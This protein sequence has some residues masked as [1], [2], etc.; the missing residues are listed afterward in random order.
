MK[1]IKDSICCKKKE[2][3]KQTGGGPVNNELS[4]VAVNTNYNSN[5]VMNICKCIINKKLK[6]IYNI[7]G[8]HIN[9]YSNAIEGRAN[10]NKGDI[11]NG[12]IVASIFV[13]LQKGGYI[14]KLSFLKDEGEKNDCAIFKMQ[15]DDKVKE[16]FNPDEICSIKEFENILNRKGVS[17]F[18]KIKDYFKEKGLYHNVSYKSEYECL[19]DNNKVNSPTIEKFKICTKVWDKDYTDNTGF[20]WNCSDLTED[21][22]GSRKYFV[23]DNKGM[24]YDNNIVIKLS[25]GTFLKFYV[26]KTKNEIHKF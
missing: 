2:I 25:N 19:C 26:N 3:E 20:Y 1:I 8:W 21:G 11:M 24:Y 5:T 17:F 13:S 12:L 14:V 4:S 10:I 9:V 6:E 23:V 16:G 22:F 7:A 15:I 18:D